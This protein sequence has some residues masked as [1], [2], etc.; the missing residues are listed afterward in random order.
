MPLPRYLPNKKKAKTE[1]QTTT[2]NGLDDYCLAK[3]I[4][5]ALIFSSS[6]RGDHSTLNYDTRIEK[7]LSLVCKRWYY[8]TQIQVINFGVFKINLDKFRTVGSHYKCKFLDFDKSKTIAPSATTSRLNPKFSAY[9]SRTPGVLKQKSYS[10]Y[11]KNTT[12]I[13][14][15]SPHVQTIDT[16]QNISLFRAILPKLRKYKHIIIEGTLKCD[17]FCKLIVALDAARVEQLQ[18]KVK[19]ERDGSMAKNFANL[20]KHLSH[21]ENLTLIWVNDTDHIFGNFLTWTIYERAF[22]LKSFH[23]FL[24]ESDSSNS[25]EN[26]QEK[27]ESNERAGFKF[28]EQVRCMQHDYLRKL[29]F[30]RTSP[31]EDHDTCKYASLIKSVLL[32]EKNVSR[33]EINDNFLIDYLITSSDRVS[34]S[35]EIEHLKFTSAI[36][37][38]LLAKLLNSKNL[39]RDY[40]SIV[41]ENTNQLDEVRLLVQNFKSIRHDKA[42]CQICLNI[43]DQKA[44]DCEE[45]V[46][47]LIQLSRQGELIVIVNAVH[48]VSIDCC[49]LMWSV[50]RALQSSANSDL[51]GRCV[52]RILLQPP[53]TLRTPSVGQQ[54]NGP[55]NYSEITIPFGSGIQNLKIN[56]TREDMTKHREI[57]KALKKDCYHQFVKS[58]RDS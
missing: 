45:K 11:T 28:L 7:N 38:N 27:I 23:V 21:L 36:N 17:E 34:T 9:G 19:I 40:L 55:A 22:R 6:Q 13:S 42:I 30:V 31:N 12:V 37:L 14:S 1:S 5:Y 52:F 26:D 8:L 20:P 49:H 4:G 32:H 51:V 33:V 2:I 54:S 29:V 16:N 41:I 35:K 44:S 39:G 46:K 57:L 43:R 58:V 10:S 47:N 24:R 50:G 56:T 53:S 15:C 3:I 18:L 48:R 25:T